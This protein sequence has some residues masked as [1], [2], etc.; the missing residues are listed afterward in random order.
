MESWISSGDSQGLGQG[1]SVELEKERLSVQF[2]VPS[3]C[4]HASCCPILR[5]RSWGWSRLPPSSWGTALPCAEHCRKAVF[6]L[7]ALTL[8]SSSRASA[9]G[10]VPLRAW[11]GA[12][13]P[14]KLGGV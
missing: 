9:K 13:S 5:G 11:S 1:T 7:Q 6:T 12:F 14:E 3:P 2:L 4:G 10:G 8:A